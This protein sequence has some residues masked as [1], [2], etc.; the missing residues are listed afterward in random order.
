MSAERSGI[1]C[2]STVYQCW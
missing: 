2:K 1:F